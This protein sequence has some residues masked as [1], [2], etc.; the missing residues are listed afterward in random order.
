MLPY[1]DELKQL[2]LPSKQYAIFGSGPLA[3]RGIREARDVDVLVKK[4]LWDSLA[5]IYPPNEKGNG[6]MIGHVELFSKWEPFDLNVDELIDTA[7]T[8]ENLPFVRMEYVIEW[9]KHVS[10]DKDKKD[11]GLI[12][13]YFKAK[14]A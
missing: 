13:E 5:K 3:I 12:E 11:L 1:L 10:R 8:I 6:L 14:K 2:N 4:D 7:E 9:K